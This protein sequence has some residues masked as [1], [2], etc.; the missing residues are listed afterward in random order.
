MKKVLYLFVACCISTVVSAQK[1]TEKDLQGTWKLAAFNAGGIYLDMSTGL[2]SISD[3]LKSQLTPDEVTELNESMK[4]G[5]E[6]LK[7]SSI[8]FT[9]TT[10]KQSIGGQIKNGTYAIKDINGEQHILSTYADGT[11]SDT[12]ISIKDKKLY[13]SKSEQGQ[14][15]ELIFNKG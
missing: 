15:A 8:S 9:G 1:I 10:V 12:A 2:A 11:T 5:I 13:I 3:E 6:P 14:T 4:Q 7:T